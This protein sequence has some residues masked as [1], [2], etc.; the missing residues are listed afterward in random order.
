MGQTDTDR[1][2]EPLIDAQEVGKRLSFSPL[3]I[4]R[5]A[6]QGKIP[7]IAFQIGSSGKCTYRFRFS[8]LQAYLTTLE[9]YPN[10]GDKSCLG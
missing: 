3:T 4:T 8:D 7:S 10:P 6:H 9:R 1:Q 5:W 2:L